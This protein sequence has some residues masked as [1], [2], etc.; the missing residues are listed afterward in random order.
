MG[1]KGEEGQGIQSVYCSSVIT[2]HPHFV[3][4]LFLFCGSR[5]RALCEGGNGGSLEDIEHAK[6]ALA[7]VVPSLHFSPP[8]LHESEIRRW[9]KMRRTKKRK[10]T[11]EGRWRRKKKE[12]SSV[13]SGYPS[14]STKQSEPGVYFPPLGLFLWLLILIF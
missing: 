13:F 3:I 10:K 6:V 14:D 5:A 9:K 12:T 11:E 2:T 7:P 1:E 8:A 4:C